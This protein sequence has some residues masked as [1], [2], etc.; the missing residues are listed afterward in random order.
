MVIANE[1]KT[2]MA[3]ADAGANATEKGDCHEESE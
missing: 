2:P 3:F 1:C